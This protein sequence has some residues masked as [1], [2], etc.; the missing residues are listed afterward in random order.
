MG[1]GGGS[2]TCLV[3]PG[4]PYL[5]SLGRREKGEII[6]YLTF[7]GVGPNSSQNVSGH[8]SQ[9]QEGNIG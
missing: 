3:L 7:E 2:P 1:G 5:P 6:A 9:D 4:G 8:G